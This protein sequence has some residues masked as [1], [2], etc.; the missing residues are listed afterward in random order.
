[1]LHDAGPS[2]V[3]SCSVDEQV[4]CF[5][6]TWQFI[7]VFTLILCW[8]VWIYCTPSHPILCSLSLGFPG[9]SFVDSSIRMPY[10]HLL[11]L[12]HVPL[13]LISLPA[14]PETYKLC[15]F[16]FVAYFLLVTTNF[17]TTEFQQ[18]WCVCMCAGTCTC[19]CVKRNF[20]LLIICN[21]KCTFSCV[22]TCRGL[23][24]RAV[25]N[26]NFWHYIE[27]D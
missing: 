21:I 24:Y 1:M 18:F 3:R 22:E 12:V 7:V 25:C 27:V 13:H 14:L 5:H 2:K 6:G 16:S 4:S 8:A 20:P 15:N 9:I 23:E 11:W 17:L 10:V 19:L 26:L